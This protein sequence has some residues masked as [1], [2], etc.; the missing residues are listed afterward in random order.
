MLYRGKWNLFDQI[1]VSPTLLGKGKGLKYDD[2]EVFMREYLFEQE[3]RYKGSP[4][5]THDGKK[6]LKGYSD[7]LPTIFYLRK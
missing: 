4:L 2:S 5:R 1:L 7:H 6:W 3:G